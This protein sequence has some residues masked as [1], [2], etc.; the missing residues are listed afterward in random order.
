MKNFDILGFK[1]AWNDIANYRDWI[2]T[3]KREETNPDSIY[4]RFDMG[5]NIFY[6]IYVVVTLPDSD[7]N[8]PENI[9][10]MRVL[11]SLAPINRYLDENLR[12]G[13][14]L[15]PEFNRV[16]DGGAPTLSYVIMYRFTFHKFSV[17]WLLTRLG[18]IGCLIFAGFK[19]PWQN[20]FSWISNLI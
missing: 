1:K 2:R 11:E 13:E 12:F 20:L 6:N 16:Y 9:L 19:I 4:R 3:I 14:Y 10:R 8:L 18:L 15:T 5:K 7:E 17:K